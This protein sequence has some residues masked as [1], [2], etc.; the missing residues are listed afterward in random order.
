VLA[1]L[2]IKLNAPYK[3]A[4]SKAWLKI[5][6]PTAAPRPARYLWQ[7]PRTSQRLPDSRGALPSIATIAKKLNRGSR[8]HNQSTLAVASPLPTFAAQHMIGL[9]PGAASYDGMAL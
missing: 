5:K 1:S 7:A 9:K 8:C 4:P 3:S 2:P 6:N